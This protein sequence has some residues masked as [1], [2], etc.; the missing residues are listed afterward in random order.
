[1]GDDGNFGIL[2]SV[3]NVKPKPEKKEKRKKLQMK[4]RP[5]RVKVRKPIS[6]VE[7]IEEDINPM[8]DVFGLKKEVTEESDYPIYDIVEENA[9]PEA[10]KPPPTKISFMAD[11]PDMQIPFSN[12]P[13]MKPHEF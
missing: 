1:M 4:M 10:P 5:L 6:Q 7:E 11:F 8:D 9:A 2:D 13:M 12:F 3:R